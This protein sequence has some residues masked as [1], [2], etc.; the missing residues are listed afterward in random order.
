MSEFRDVGVIV[1][2]SVL[3]RRE[4]EVLLLDTVS[5]RKEL[6]IALKGTLAAIRTIIEDLAFSLIR[7]VAY[8]CS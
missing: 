6:V 5:A 1:P 4:K 8:I 7:S 2:R 3:D